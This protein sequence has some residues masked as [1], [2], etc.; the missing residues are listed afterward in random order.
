MIIR[1]IS[2]KYKAFHIPHHLSPVICYAS[3]YMVRPQLETQS[4]LV[5]RQVFRI[6]LGCGYMVTFIEDGSTMYIDG[7]TVTLLRVSMLDATSY[8]RVPLFCLPNRIFL[9]RI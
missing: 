8:I 6:F 5:F 9:A 3:Y 4:L 7:S 2:Y 1:K